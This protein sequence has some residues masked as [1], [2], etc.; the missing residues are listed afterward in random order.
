MKSRLLLL[1]VAALVAAAPVRATVYLSIEQAQALMFPGA[2]LT[3][4]FITLTAEQMKAIEKDSDVNVLSPQLKVWKSS[5]GGWFIADQVVGK[6]DF[7]PFALA[8]DEHGAV[9]DV[10]ILEYRETYGDQVRNANWRAQFTGKTHSAP[11]KVGADIKNISGATLSSRHITDG[12]KRL[13]STYALV[14]A[15]QHA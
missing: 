8:L 13:L 10:E 4:A 2:T 3:P 11:L 9:K 15:Q 1:P 7:I 6:H 12:V 5:S 14:L